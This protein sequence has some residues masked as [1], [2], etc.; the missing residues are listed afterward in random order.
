MLSGLS[1]FLSVALGFTRFLHVPNVKTMNMVGY[2]FVV[3]S[4]H[5]E[6]ELNCLG[7]FCYTRMCKR[8]QDQRKDSTSEP[9]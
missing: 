8:Q 2:I 4:V 7:K 3:K 9:V 5:L 1:T 6:V